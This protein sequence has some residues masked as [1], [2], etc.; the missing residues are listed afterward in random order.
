[1]SADPTVPNTMN[2]QSYNRYS[3]VN[4]RPLSFTDPSGYDDYGSIFVHPSLQGDSIPATPSLAGNPGTQGYAGGL[5]TGPA[6]VYGAE[7]F[8]VGGGIAGVAGGGGSPFGGGAGGVGSELALVGAPVP[9]GTVVTIS[10]APSDSNGITTIPG[11]ISPTYETAWTNSSGASWSHSY[12]FYENVCAFSDTACTVPRAWNALLHNAYPGQNPNSAVQNGKSYY[13]MDSPQWGA[14]QV[15]TN[16]SNLTEANVTLQSHMFCC[17]SVIQQLVVQQDGI[18]IHITGSGSNTSFVTWGLNYVA[19][20]AF[21]FAGVPAISTYV[22]T[23]Y[24]QENGA[25]PAG[26]T[27][28]YGPPPGL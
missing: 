17:G 18:Y 16:P 4:N 27:D 23:S 15:F 26:S 14:I 3:Y 10:E 19:A 5:F 9:V 2:G 1:M 8:Q 12:S 24:Y 21:P 11:Y 22:D 6:A 7:I 28:Y 13:V 25:W 20:Y